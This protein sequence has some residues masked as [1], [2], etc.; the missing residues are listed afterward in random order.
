MPHV[1]KK[2]I[3]R[4]TF[5][6]I[7]NDLITM[8]SGLRSKHEVKSLLNEILT[9]TER[10]MLA[11]R[12]AIIFM[13]KKDYSFEVVWRTLKVSPSTVA[14]FWKQ[15]RQ[16]SFPTISSRIQNEKTTK[17]FWDSLERALLVG[18]PPMGPRQAKRLYPY[19]R[20]SSFRSSIPYQK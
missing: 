19:K 3:K 4:K 20:K 5:L 1:S 12:L 14:R 10:I 13:L 16:H 8:I 15:T 9:P 17:E 2:G 18:M 6:Q 7:S 11:K